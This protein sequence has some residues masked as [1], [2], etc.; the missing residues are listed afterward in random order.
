LQNS[1]TP[2]WHVLQ[3]VRAFEAFR[4]LVLGTSQPCLKIVKQKLGRQIKL[5]KEQGL[6]SGGPGISDEKKSIR[7][8]TWPGQRESYYRFVEP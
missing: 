5:E 8:A 4:E 2:A 3:P 7:P 6:A 1:A